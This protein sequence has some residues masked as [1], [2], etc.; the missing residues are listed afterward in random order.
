[1]LKHIHLLDQM[2]IMREVEKEVGIS[3]VDG[4][5]S[6]LVFTKEHRVEHNLQDT[7]SKVQNVE[8]ISKA[9]NQFSNDKQ[10]FLDLVQQVDRSVALE[11]FKKKKMKWSR[12][13]LHMMT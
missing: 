8:S 1:M 12:L 11:E 5:F 9:N 3:H 10:L 7:F 2:L 4:S 6:L 13:T